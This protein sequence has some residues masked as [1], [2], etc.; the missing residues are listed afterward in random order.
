MPITVTVRITGADMDRVREVADEY[1]ELGNELR[2]LLE[3]HGLISHRRFYNGSEIL[4]IDEWD[5]E[6]GFRAFL[7]VG[8]PVIAKLAHLRG[9]DVPTDQIWYPY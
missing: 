9:T 3:K 6:D 1:P 4:D 8:S 5:S 2:G 7:E